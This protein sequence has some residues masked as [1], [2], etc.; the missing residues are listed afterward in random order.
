MI[1]YSEK[2]GILG[3]VVGNLVLVE[4]ESVFMVL[5]SDWMLIGNL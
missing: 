4:G 2:Y 1:V 3:L 5:N